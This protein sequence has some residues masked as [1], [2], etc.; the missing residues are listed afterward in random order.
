MRRTGLAVA[1]AMLL[2]GVLAQPMSARAAESFAFDVVG[3]E[4]HVAFLNFPYFTCF[5]SKKTPDQRLVEFLDFGKPA[6]VFEYE[7][8]P[9]RTF[10]NVIDN[11]VFEILEYEKV[12][13]HTR[14]QVLE[15]L[16]FSLWEN[17]TG[18][19]ETHYQF[20]RLPFSSLFAYTSNEEMT[21]W[22]LLYIPITRR[23]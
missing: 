5:E 11:P 2:L 22:D 7:R 3:P 23:K 6:A 17:Q 16:L 1:G 12:P 4:T 15:I 18:E 20:A 13:K 10:W 21:R 14:F 8:T 19:D 9:G